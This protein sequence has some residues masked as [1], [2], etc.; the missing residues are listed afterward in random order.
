MS[1]AAVWLVTALGLFVLSSSCHPA[2]AEAPRRA[3]GPAGPSDRPARP[4]P[5]AQPARCPDCLRAGAARTAIALPA[6]VPLAGYGGLGR[7]LLIPDL[8]DRYPY[9]FWFKPSRGV[10]GPIMA[11][12]LV[13]E[14]GTARVLWIA[15]DLVAV[16]PQLVAAL[17][18]RLTAEGLRYTALIVAAS[19]THS[20]PGAFARSRIFGFLT[21]DRFVP[22]IAEHLLQGM[23]RSARQA[24][25]GKIPA[26]VGGGNGHAPGI[27][28]SRLD[29]P[30]D[31]EVG[32]LK[33]VAAGGAPVALLWNYAVHGTALGKGNLR[34]S[35]DLMGVAGQRLER[36]LGVPALYTNGAVADVSPARHGPEGAEFLGEALARQ[37]LAVWD[38]VTPE[39]GSTLHALVEP[40]QLPPPRLALRGCLGR[41]LPR[42][43]TVGLGWALPDRSE[44]V[45]VAVGGH[46]W[47]T[48]PGEIQTQLGQEVKAEGR[49]IFRSTFVVGLANDYLGY[50]L[51]REAHHRVGYIQCASPYGETAGEVVAERAKALLRRLGQSLP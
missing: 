42:W 50:F 27:A 24:E 13:L 33:V 48:I 8:L 45:G 31:S 46:A 44:L 10:D 9:A 30:L 36:H 47:L 12:A 19:H 51:T 2:F 5:P 40:L 18:S 25:F 34:L 29:L 23:I 1:R 39:T 41:W 16:D 28:A 26:R 3:S 49:R 21:L 43:L 38:R 4:P 7:R 20:G 11:R 15:V 14:Q 22:E 17:K 32:V 37:V 6:G 35:G